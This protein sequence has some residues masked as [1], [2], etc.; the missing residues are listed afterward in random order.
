MKFADETKA[1]TSSATMH[2]ARRLGSQPHPCEN[3]RYGTLRSSIWEGYIRKRGNLGGMSQ[4][5][6]QNYGVQLAV[7]AM[8]AAE[9]PYCAQ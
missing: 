1:C 3:L 8:F 9:P 7:G 6:A 2:F 5:I 4:D